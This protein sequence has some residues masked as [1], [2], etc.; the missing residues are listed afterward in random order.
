VAG[1]FFTTKAL[2]DLVSLEITLSFLFFFIVALLLLFDTLMMMIL[3]VKIPKAHSQ[4]VYPKRLSVR[5]S[6]RL[7]AMIAWKFAAFG[8]YWRG[9]YLR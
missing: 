8:I 2:V 7:P 9:C 5:G 1:I 4:I 6:Y 3:L